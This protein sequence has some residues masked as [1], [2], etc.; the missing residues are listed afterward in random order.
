MGCHFFERLH[1]GALDLFGGE[2]CLIRLEL[3]FD[4]V[5]VV[6]K[7]IAAFRGSDRARSMESALAGV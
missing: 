4:P 1:V 5:E 7:N 3:W 6:G 2:A